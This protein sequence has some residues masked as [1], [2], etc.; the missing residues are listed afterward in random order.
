LLTAHA[1]R[2]GTPSPRSGQTLDIAAHDLCDATQHR[3]RRVEAGG[4]TGETTN[5][6]E[7]RSLL[8]GQSDRIVGGRIG[9]MECTSPS[10]EE[11]SSGKHHP[12]QNSDRGECRRKR[13]A[14][15]RGGTNC[16]AEGR[17]IRDD[18]VDGGDESPIDDVGDGDEDAA[19]ERGPPGEY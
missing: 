12:A 11:R 15:Q 4:R 5:R 3:R 18:V 8:S 2:P 7:G 13:V 10:I 17:K 6:R 19:S 9:H 1:D 14:E 16:A